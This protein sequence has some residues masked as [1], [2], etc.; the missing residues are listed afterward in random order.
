L[1]TLEAPTVKSGK[2]SSHEGEEFIYVLSGQVEVALGANQDLLNPGDSIQYSSS[3]PHRVSSR[4][5]EK[6]QILAVIWSP[7]VK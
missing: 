4:D 6:A 2:L 7:P 1:V 5:G 3:I